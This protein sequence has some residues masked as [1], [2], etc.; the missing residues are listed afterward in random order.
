MSAYT[1][2]ELA[3]LTGVHPNTVRLYEAWGYIDG[4]KRRDNGYRVFTHRHLSQMRLARLALPGPYPVEGRMVH[5]LVRE[6]AAGRVDTALSLAESYRQGVLD[7]IERADIAQGI[8]DHWFAEK[9][10]DPHEIRCTTR[11][12]AAAAAGRSVETLRTWERNGLL[13]IR[14]DG[15]GRLVFSAFDMEKIQVIRLLRDCGYSIA[16]LHRVFGKEDELTQRPSLVL[17]LGADTEG[18]SYVT[19]RYMDYLRD[20]RQ[21]AGSIIRFLRKDMG[22]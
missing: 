11:R 8:L 14:R 20:H 1:T 6:Y 5:R 16:S 12:R 13:H 3:R 4:A 9:S 17:A 2:S 7:E 15:R 18:L 10:A 19:D 22:R 21:R